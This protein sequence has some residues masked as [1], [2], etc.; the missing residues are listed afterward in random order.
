LVHWSNF[1]I[2]PGDCSAVHGISNFGDALLCSI[3]RTGNKEG[4]TIYEM[5]DRG[6]N[7]GWH[8]NTTMKPIDFVYLDPGYDGGFFVFFD[9]KLKK[10]VYFRTQFGQPVLTVSLPSLGKGFEDYYEPSI[11]LSYDGSLLAIVAQPRIR[12]LK[13]KVFVFNRDFPDD[14]SLQHPRVICSSLY[15]LPPLL[16]SKF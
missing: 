5:I 16:P 4:K 12:G 9:E 1:N 2:P 11:S 6:G 10:F 14:F 15:L 7:A 3:A 13:S 8:I